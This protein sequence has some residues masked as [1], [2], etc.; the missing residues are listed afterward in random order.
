MKIYI[1][2]GKTVVQEV[3]RKSGIREKNDCFDILFGRFT[4]HVV[5]TMNFFDRSIIHI[6]R[7][8]R[9][10]VSEIPENKNR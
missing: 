2:K 10:H 1:T 9:T 3:Q 4:S 7:N 5:K 6:T 8:F